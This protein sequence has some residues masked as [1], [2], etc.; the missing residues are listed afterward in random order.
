MPKAST[1]FADPDG[2][3]EILRSNA[4]KK[5]NVKPVDLDTLRPIRSERGYK[6]TL[7]RYYGIR[8]VEALEQRLKKDPLLSKVHTS[9]KKTVKKKGGEISRRKAM[10]DFNL[11]NAQMDQIKPGDVKDSPIKSDA[12]R[13]AFYYNIVDVQ[14]LARAVHSTTPGGRKSYDSKK[15]STDLP[16]SLLSHRKS[17]E[18]GLG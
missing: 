12:Q 1:K 8:D 15:R 14:N 2:T 17:A 3:E 6:N 16:V 11:D 7:V 18:T 10:K 9:P 13:K 4:T 5:Y